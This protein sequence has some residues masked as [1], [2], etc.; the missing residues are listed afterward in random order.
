MD[1]FI[2]HHTTLKRKHEEEVVE[3]H[4][5]AVERERLRV[6]M[7]RLRVESQKISSELEIMKLAFQ[8]ENKKLDLHY[9]VLGTN[10]GLT[11]LSDSSI[12]IDTILNAYHVLNPTHRPYVYWLCIEHSIPNS[13][14]LKQALQ[15]HK[16]NRYMKWQC[17]PP[18]TN[19]TAQP[20]CEKNTMHKYYKS[21]K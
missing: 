2:A 19:A 11:N 5:S 10:T 9:P 12:C 21:S 14:E 1:L 16:I 3:R 13:H 20:T 8:L 18:V 4:G 17:K 15:N 7:E 6:E